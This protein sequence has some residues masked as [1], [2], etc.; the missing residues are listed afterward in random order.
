M[1][2]LLMLAFSRGKELAESRLPQNKKPES[3][4]F[5]HDSRKLSNSVKSIEFPSLHERIDFVIESRQNGKII[6][7]RLH[8]LE[9][10]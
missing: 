8:S 2:H 6:L 5:W 4:A 10:L 9:F 3:H 1:M 7:T